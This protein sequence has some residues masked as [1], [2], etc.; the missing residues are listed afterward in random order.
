MM[1]K[2]WNWRV[3]MV[4][5]QCECTSA[6]LP[7]NYTLKNDQDGKFCYTYFTTVIK[8]QEREKTY[9]QIEGHMDGGYLLFVKDKGV[10]HPEKA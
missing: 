2:F 7:L 8:K 6:A 10:G 4:A 1:I 5:Q 3:V 9:L